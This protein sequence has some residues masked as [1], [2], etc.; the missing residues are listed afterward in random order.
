M[1]ELETLE[2]EYRLLA[3][4]VIYAGFENGADPKDEARL[5]ELAEELLRRNVIGA[6]DARLEPVAA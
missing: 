5:A 2:A 4:K 6:S 3:T 1:S